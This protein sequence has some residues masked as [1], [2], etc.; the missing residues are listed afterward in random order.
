[1]Y[2]IYKATN[3]VNGKSYIGFDSKWPRRQIV[4]K[5]CAGRGDTQKFYHAIRKYGFENFEWEVLEQSE[6]REFLLNERESYYIDYYD[7]IKSGYN[8]TK[9]GEANKGW[10]PSEE[11]RRKI[12]E[13]NKGKKAWNKGKSS[14]WT[15]KRN[16]DNVG[17]PIVGLQKEYRITDPEGK[18]YNVK[19][20]KEF[21]KKHGLH[22]GNMCSVASG[23]LKH[24][25]KWLC[26]KI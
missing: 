7:S 2:T 16:K 19:G 4:H 13:A 26:E 5:C 17:K 15:A 10:K 6:D 21:C 14:P 11:T 24:Y 9:G 23:K 20:L 1:M 8:T 22:A 25:K 12:S 3:K 18:V